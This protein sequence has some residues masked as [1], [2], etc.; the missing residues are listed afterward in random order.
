[1]LD[2]ILS[3]ITQVYDIPALIAWGGYTILFAIIFAETGLLIGFFLPGDSL[4]I[5]AGLFAALG[6]LDI[7][8]LLIVLIPAAIIGDAVGYTIGARLGSR[9]YSRK[10]SFFFRKKHLI[11]AKAFYDKHGGKTIILARFIPV[12][13]TFAP[14]VAGAAGMT[15]K[16]FATYNIIGATLWVGG[17]TL[18]GYFLGG[19]VPDLEHNILYLVGAVIVLS[20]VPVALEYLKMRRNG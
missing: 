1:M 19:V 7:F 12:I 4:L 20:L 3:L 18:L 9:L 17:V 11:A 13:R 8:I 6:Q 2:Q 15:Y 16:H 10:D 5:S 14:V